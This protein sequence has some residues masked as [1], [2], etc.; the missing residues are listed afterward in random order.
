MTLKINTIGL[1]LHKSISDMPHLLI[2]GQTGAGKSVML[3]VI[4]NTLTK[5]M[6]ATELRLILIDPK[7]VEL[8]HFGQLP[9][10]AQPVVYDSIQAIKVL[11]D[12]VQEMEKR[13][14]TLTNAGVRSIDDYKGK[15]PKFLIVIDEFADLIM[16]SARMAA[17]ENMDIKKF[18]NNLMDVLD[19]SPTGKFTQKATKEAIRRTL[20]DGPDDA[21][22]SIIRIAQKSRAVGIHLV[23]ATQ[24]PSADVVTGLIKANIPTKIAFATTNTVNSKIIID[25]TGA[26]QLTGKGDMLFMQPGENGLKRL[27][28]LYI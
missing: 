4:L 22:T 24:R 9:H 1:V 19:E 11:D 3:N 7:R 25:Q 14:K 15:M 10:L 21:Q 6:S 12:L 27:Q 13:Y 8:A 23:L 5:Q 28:G 16:T 20:A 17:I 18:N 26:E 2:A